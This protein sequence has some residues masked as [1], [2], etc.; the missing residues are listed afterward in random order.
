MADV[1]SET[2]ALLLDRLKTALSG[3]PWLEV[4]GKLWTASR[5]ALRGVAE[6]GMYEVLEYQSTL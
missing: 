1:N 2:A 3:L 6:E 4:L 5:N